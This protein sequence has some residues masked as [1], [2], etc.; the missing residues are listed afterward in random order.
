MD[1]EGEES[2]QIFRVDSLCPSR[3]TNTS[4]FYQN[5]GFNWGV[6]VDNRNITEWFPVI[7]IYNDRAFYQSTPQH[8]FESRSVYAPV[9]IRLNCGESPTTLK[10]VWEP[11][12]FGLVGI[13][14][15]DWD[16]IGGLNEKAFDEKW[17][18]EDWDFM[19]RLVRFG[20]EYDRV[21]HPK[22]FHYYHSKRGMWTF[23]HDTSR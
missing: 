9:I 7:M 4:K 21:R 6:R 19:E 11:Q 23:D 16:R 18:G 13:F 20:M 17:G 2:Y 22:I 1:V 8:C 15:S 14:K 5:K 12:G 3:I 10:G